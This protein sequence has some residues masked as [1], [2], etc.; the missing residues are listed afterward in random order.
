MGD[1]LRISDI[2][3]EGELHA[4]R[5]E[6]ESLRALVESLLAR[7]PLAAPAFRLAPERVRKAS[8]RRRELLDLLGDCDW[9]K[10]EAARRLGVTR[11]TVWRRMKQFGISLDGPQRQTPT[12]PR[13]PKALP[14]TRPQRISPSPF[15]PSVD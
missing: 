4:L 1:P 11:V 7:E 5:E 14:K 6:V 12:R 2:E 13:K 10:A 8:R 9:N 3:N 15:D